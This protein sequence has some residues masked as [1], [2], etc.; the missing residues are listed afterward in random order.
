[1]CT[2]S[3][4]NDFDKINIL[5]DNTGMEHINWGVSPALL[6][7]GDKYLQRVRNE[8]W[9]ISAT[10]MD[11]PQEDYT[12]L[13]AIK[14]TGGIIPDKYWPEN[15]KRLL[16][17]IDISVDFGVE[18]LAFHF[19]FLDHSNK[20]QLKTFSDRV[21]QL[22]DYAAAKNVKLL[23]ETGQESA[24]DLKLFIEEFN[25]PTIAVNFDPAN[26]VL[27]DKGIS[28]DAVKTLAPWVKHI[29]IKDA[30]RTK[31]PGTWGAE[32]PWGQG[33]VNTTAFLDMLTEIGYKGCLAVEREAGDSRLEDIQMA[34]ESLKNYNP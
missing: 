11:F 4:K 33:E 3:L 1:M 25:N 6:A 26:I 14:E 32:V 12:T 24:E 15:K 22:A 34:I 30:I 20:E 21:Q 28:V 10:M 17:A 8:G 18:L 7:D 27:Y 2:W 5:R 19:G 9:K 16:E 23:M 29:H 31:E 13:E